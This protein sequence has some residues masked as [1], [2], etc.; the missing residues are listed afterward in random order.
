MPSSGSSLTS[1][2]RSSSIGKARTSVGPSPSIHFSLSPVMVSSSTALMHSSA[3]G[4][5]RIRS[6]TNRLSPTSRSTS[7]AAPDSL[8]TSMLMAGRPSAT[9]RPGTAL[10]AGL[11]LLGGVELVV[12]RH[13]LSDQPVPHHVV[14]REPAEADVLD[15]VEDLLHHPQPRLGAAG[16]V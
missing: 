16:Q 9:G 13:D 8:S 15:L 2:G 7:N 10:L 3:S 6:S 11:A 5:T 1:P 12:G 4:C 14:G